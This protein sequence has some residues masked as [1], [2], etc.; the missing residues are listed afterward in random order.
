MTL[1]RLRNRDYAPVR[2][3]YSGMDD[4]FNWFAGEM[5]GQRGCNNHPSVNI[6][7][8]DDDYRI[9][10][11]VPGYNKE[12]I[13][14]QFENGILSVSHEASEKDESGRANYLTREFQTVGFER[15]FRLSDR[16]ASDKIT[17]RYENGI[18]EVTIPKKEEAK[19]KPVREISI[20]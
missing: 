9:E 11:L 10:M 13:R 16:L 4:M 12:D 5:G 17:A 14:I 2:H 7:E 1:V 3:S 19:A 15:S 20:K 6:V 18:L 8:N